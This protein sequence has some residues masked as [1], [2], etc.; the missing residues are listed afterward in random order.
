[1]IWKGPI[2]DNAGK[3]VIEKDKIA[4]DEFLGGIKFYVKGVDGKVPGEK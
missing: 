1:M 2:S 4:D 3:V